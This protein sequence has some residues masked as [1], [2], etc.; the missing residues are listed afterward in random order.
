MEEVLQTLG[1]NVSSMSDP[2]E[3]STLLK[4]ADGR[5]CRPAPITPAAFLKSMPVPYKGIICYGAVFC[6]ESLLC[7]AED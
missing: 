4:L 5:A 2:H 6:D 3:T 1:E 7:D